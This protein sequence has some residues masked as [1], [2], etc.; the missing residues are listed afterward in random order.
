MDVSHDNTSQRGR[1]R[2]EIPTRV[3]HGSAECRT[4]AVVQVRKRILVVLHTTTSTDIRTGT[5]SK[6]TRT[7]TST[8]GGTRTVLSP[9]LAFSLILS[10][11][12]VLLVSPLSSVYAHTVSQFYG[13]RTSSNSSRQYLVSKEERISYMTMSCGS[14]TCQPRRAVAQLRPTP[15]STCRPSVTSRLRNIAV[16]A[17]LELNANELRS[18]VEYL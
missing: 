7:C 17:T 1:P 18:G 10:T 3:S 16:R 13:T 4:A 11:V 15:S 8:R 6:L 14:V 2:S 5:T 9:P 12:R